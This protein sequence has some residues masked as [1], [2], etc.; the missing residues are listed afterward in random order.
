LGKFIIVSGV[1]DNIYTS[2]K[3]TYINF[4]KDWHTDFSVQIENKLLKK[5]PEFSVEK[6][7][8]KK[9]SVRGWLEYYNGPFMKIYNIAN[10]QII[11][12]K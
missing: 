3:D 9:I 1:V 12:G 5:Q 8:G 4:G 2:K 11:Y 10:I 6:V 7:T